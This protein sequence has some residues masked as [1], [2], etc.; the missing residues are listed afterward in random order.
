[1]KAIAVKS[2]YTSQECPRCHYVARSNRPKQ[3]TC[4]CGV[5]GWQAH[6]NHNATLNIASRLGDREIQ[7]ASTRQELKALLEQRHQ[8]WRAETGWS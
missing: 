4:C 3:E 2:A 6:A 7:S 8:R 5:C 1:M